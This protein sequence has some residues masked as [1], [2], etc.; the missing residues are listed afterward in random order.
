[1]RIWAGARPGQPRNVFTC[2]FRAQRPVVVVLR[3]KLGQLFAISK[4]QDPH[5]IGTYVVALDEGPAPTTT[6]GN[7]A[8]RAE[9]RGCGWPCC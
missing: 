5:D 8:A 3:Q 1:M 7:G 2:Q 9:A 6:Q 4:L